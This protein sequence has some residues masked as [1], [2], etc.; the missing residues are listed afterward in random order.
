MSCAESRAHEASPG[1]LQ[2][3]HPANMQF[4][5]LQPHSVRHARPRPG[6]VRATH[7]PYPTRSTSPAAP[8][9]PP[10]ISTA[11]PSSARRAPPHCRASSSAAGSTHKRALEG[12]NTTLSAAQASQ[13][14]WWRRCA[15]ADSRV[16]LISRPP[17]SPCFSRLLLLRVALPWLLCADNA[18]VGLLSSQWWVPAAASAASRELE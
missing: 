18:P 3:Q 4:T 7:R 10:P 15:A 13:A 1:T 17:S 2:L 16:A 11:S 9:R 8:S 14:R 6:C 12:R 5:R